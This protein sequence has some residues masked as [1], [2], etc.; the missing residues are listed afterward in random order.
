M[1]V[2]AASQN[3]ADA[4]WEVQLGIVTLRFLHYGKQILK[5]VC[6]VGLW[7]TMKNYCPGKSKKMDPRWFRR[8]GR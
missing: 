7:M 3:N 4:Y 8:R 5:T 2:F 1:R 6:I